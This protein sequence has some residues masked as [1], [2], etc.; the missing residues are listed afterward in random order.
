[1]SSAHSIREVICTL[2]TE[3]EGRGLVVL[4][5]ATA[6]LWRDHLSGWQWVATAACWVLL[7]AVQTVRAH[8]VEL[9]MRGGSDE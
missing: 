9:R 5:L 4:A 7:E 1:M 8:G 6:A 3:G 2:I